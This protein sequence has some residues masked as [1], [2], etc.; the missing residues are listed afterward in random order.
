M[1]EELKEAA[2]TDLTMSDEEE[3]DVVTSERNDRGVLHFLLNKGLYQQWINRDGNTK[4]AYGT[5]ESCTFTDGKITFTVALDLSVGHWVAFGVRNEAPNS[6]MGGIEE[7][8]AWAGY[9]SFLSQTEGKK[10]TCSDL[11][12]YLPAETKP[13][14]RHYIVS[15]VRASSQ[16]R[17]MHLVVKGH[18]V[19][20]KVK[21][22]NIPN[23][24]LGLFITATPIASLN[25]R[26]TSRNAPLVLEE[27]ELVDLGV[28]G[29]LRPEDLKL[30]H[31][32]IVKNFVHEWKSENWSFDAKCS[33]GLLLDITDD[34]TGDLSKVAEDNI[35]VFTNETDGNENAT[36]VAK[37][38]PEGAVHYYLG[39]SESG[40]GRLS[41]PTD[42]TEL[43]LKVDYGAMYESVRVR[44]GYSRVS[45]RQLK[46][47]KM[48]AATYEKGVLSNLS[49]LTS[50]E[51]FDVQIFLE[52]LN[53]QWAEAAVF[54]DMGAVGRAMLVTL[55]LL[56]RAMAISNEASNTSL[57][58]GLIQSLHELSLQFFD[59]FDYSTNRSLVLENEWYSEL[60]ATALKLRVVKSV[61][62]NTHLIRKAIQNLI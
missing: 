48:K 56:R 18:H 13:F 12:Q 3:P 32:F 36:V 40:Q 34:D 46:A 20:L 1:S 60:L 10:F 2:V 54:N 38:D 53:S 35:V 26:G 4:E 59:Q 47:E 43:K 8:D 61:G 25:S 9:N 51:V 17:S 11:S 31:V 16:Q 23:G 29:P 52:K 58:E 14:Y 22:S 15:T 45:G 33:D 42:G 37:D 27:G 44:N 57:H 55:V 50:E 24:G 21:E 49:M 62:D 28:Y 41:I 6:R 19:Q 30:D 7:A 5:F 39:Y